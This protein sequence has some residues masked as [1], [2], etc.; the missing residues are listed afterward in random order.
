MKWV[1]NWR[2]WN[3]HTHTIGWP[4][5]LHHLAS[6]QSH[7]KSET[8]VPKQL[9]LAEESLRK[10]P[11]VVPRAWP[12]LSQTGAL[13][14][15]LNPLAVVYKFLQSPL[16]PPSVLFY[17]FEFEKVLRDECHCF[18]THGSPPH[19]FLWG[20]LYEMKFQFTDIPLRA[21]FFLPQIPYQDFL[22]KTGQYKN[23]NNVTIVF[24]WCTV[25]CN[26]CY[27]CI[28]VSFYICL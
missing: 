26:V 27:F 28:T 6:T 8:C 19:C 12:W 16:R 25:K 24:F 9:T 22:L 21:Q 1:R 15:P 23:W 7:L 11:K 5:L 2:R 18:A 4:S 3:T 20:I 10:R 13:K 14:I 17:H